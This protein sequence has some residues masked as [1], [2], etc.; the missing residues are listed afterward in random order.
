M[1]FIN[2]ISVLRLKGNERFNAVNTFWMMTIGIVAIATIAILILGDMVNRNIES[3]MILHDFYTVI[4]IMSGAGII[5]IL[6]FSAQTVNGAVTSMQVLAILSAISIFIVIFTG[7]YG[8]IFYRLPDENSAKSKI[9]KIFPYAH[10]PLFEIM[11][12]VGLIG[13]LWATMI[14]YLVYHWKEKMFVYKSA[15]YAVISLISIGIMYALIISLTG[16]IPTK[17]ASVQG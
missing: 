10:E 12:Y 11:E 8:Y 5:G 15:K 9:M 14:A 13:S 4:A 17:I 6:L 2:H 7:V 16:I 1:K 3:A